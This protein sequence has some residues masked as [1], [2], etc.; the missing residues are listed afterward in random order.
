MTAAGGQAGRRRV[1]SYGVDCLRTL[2]T[3]SG[4]G[5]REVVAT[6]DRV[7]PSAQALIGAKQSGQA[8]TTEGGLQQPLPPVGPRA[9]G[10]GRPGFD[11]AIRPGRGARAVRE[12]LH[13]RFRELLHCR[14]ASVR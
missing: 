9:S 10:R 7:C 12:L 11:F 5:P 3:A 8:R 6:D 13:C 14:F 4:R 2:G 1:R